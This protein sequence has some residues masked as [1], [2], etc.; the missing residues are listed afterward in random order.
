MYCGRPLKKDRIK[1]ILKA[2]ILVL[3]IILS[4]TIIWQ[5]QRGQ[6]ISLKKDIANL[7]GSVDQ[8]QVELKKYK[9][10]DFDSL[11]ELKAFLEE[12]YTDKKEWRE[13]DY[14]CINFAKDLKINAAKKGYNISVVIANYEFEGEKLGHAFNA[15]L[16]KGGL[17]FIEPQNDKTYYLMEELIAEIMSYNQ[18]Y[19]I[20]RKVYSSEIKIQEY[21]IIW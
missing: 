7:Q 16:I 11:Q 8:L 2:I 12:D 17:I 20:Y 19:G 13:G 1:T 18:I 3:I 6:I 21:A 10:K 15:A 9:L 4:N 5:Y 14:V